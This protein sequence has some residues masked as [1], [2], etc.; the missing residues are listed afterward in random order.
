M[1]DAFFR[2][3]TDIEQTRRQIQTGLSGIASDLAR[4]RGGR[5]NMFDGLVAAATEAATKARLELAKV[6]NQINVGLRN[7][8][9]AGG[10]TQLNE[11]YKQ[12]QQVAAREARDRIRQQS[13]ALGLS[14]GETSNA[15]REGQRLVRAQVKELFDHIARSLAAESRGVQPGQISAR[16]VQRYLAGDLGAPRRYNQLLSRGPQNDDLTRQTLSGAATTQA[17]RREAAMWTEALAIDR[18]YVAQNSNELREQVAIAKSISRQMR[19]REAEEERAALLAAREAARRSPQE[20]A[21]RE[22]TARQ[23]QASVF[24]DPTYQQLSRGRAYAG[25]QV[26][27]P[28]PG[29]GEGL[30]RLNG[31]KATRAYEDYVQALTK[32]AKDLREESKRGSLS[33]SFLGGLT[34]SGFGGHSTGF[35]ATGI[36][37]SFGS[38]VKFTTQYQALQLIRNAF[39]DTIKEA[40]DYRDSLTD[41]E[42]A[43]GQGARVNDAYVD[44]LSNIS[45]FAGGNVGQALDAAARGV[46]AFTDRTAPQAEKQAAGTE[47][48][49]LATQL[50]VITGQTIPDAMGD[51]VAIGKSFELPLDQLGQIADAVSAAK[52][53]GGDPQ[54]I[55]QGT[56]N[57]AVALKAAGFTVADSAQLMSAVIAQLHES[58]QAAATR[59]SRIVS[60]SGTATGRQFFRS[61]N[62]DPNQSGKA[63]IVALAQVYDSLGEA[64]QKQALATLGGASNLR[65]FKAVIDTIKN[66]DGFI[67]GF[68]T[69]GRGQSEFDRKTQNL[70]GHLKI[71]AGTISNIQNEVFDSGAFAPFLAALATLQP[72]LATVETLLKLFNQLKDTIEHIPGL[73][74]E[75]GGV[76]LGE[77]AVGIGEIVL[78]TKGLNALRARQSVNTAE[79]ASLE[80]SLATAKRTVAQATGEETGLEAANIAAHREAIVIIED[81]ILALRGLTAARLQAGE[82][83]VAEAAGGRI[84][85]VAS[86]LPFGNTIGRGAEAARAGAGR[87]GGTQLLGT[88][89]GRLGLWG[90]ALVVSVQTIKSFQGALDLDTQSLKASRAALTNLGKVATPGDAVSAIQSAAKERGQSSSGF[91]GNVIDDIRKTD[92]RITGH[93]SDFGRDAERD[94]QVLN[95]AAR[96]LKAWQKAVDDY[97]KNRAQP[98]EFDDVFGDVS[99]IDSLKAGFDELAAAGAS[100]SRIIALLNKALDNTGQKGAFVPRGANARIGAALGLSAQDVIL[101]NYREGVRSKAAAAG[102]PLQIRDVLGEDKYNDNWSV[103]NQWVRDRIS[104]DKDL[105]NNWT[106]PKVRAEAERRIAEEMLGQQTGR[107]YDK[108]FPVKDRVQLGKDVAGVLQTYLDEALPEG[109]FL[110]PE[111]VN[112]AAGKMAD[113]L[114]GK[115]PSLDRD[116]LVA[117]WQSK[118]NDKLGVNATLTSEQQ[119]VLDPAMIQQAGLDVEQT[120]ALTGDP[121]AAQ[122][123]RVATISAQIKRDIRSGLTPS[124]A[125]I[126]AYAEAVKAVG[127]AIQERTNAMGMALQGTTNLG[128]AQASVQA[129]RAAVQ[130]TTYDT[131]EFW[132]SY[133]EYNKTIAQLADAQ[134]EARIAHRDAGVHLTGGAGDSLRQAQAQ[135]KDAQDRYNSYKNVQFASPADFA[136]GG[137]FYKKPP[138]TPKQAGTDTGK[139]F[140]AGVKTTDYYNAGKSVGE[141][142]IAGFRASIVP[143]KPGQPG[144]IGPVYTPPAPYKAPAISPDDPRWDDPRFAATHQLPPAPVAPK[145]AAVPKPSTAVPPI[146]QAELD[147]RAQAVNEA[148]AALVQARQQ[149][150][151]A[152]KQAREAELQRQSARIQSKVF[153]GAGIQE[154]TAQIQIARLALRTYAKNSTEWYNALGQL[155]QAQVALSNALL[156]AANN[157]RLLAIDLTNPVAQAHAVTQAALAKLRADKKLGAPKEVLN[158]DQ[159]A[160]REAQASEERAKFDQR[161]ADAQVNERLGRISHQAYIHYLQGEHDRLTAIAHK[162]RQQIDMLNEIDLLLLE[163]S[164]QLQGQF[165]LGDIKLPTPYEVRRSIAQGTQAGAGTQVATVQNVQIDISGGDIAVIKG[166]ISQYLGP[167]SFSRAA[168]SPPK[169]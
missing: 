147:R 144:F 42:V 153:P 80:A 57:A 63:S 92:A 14:Q 116:K 72:T 46:R 136:P 166:V 64:Q 18:R 127:D 87:L 23:L 129:A 3:G 53:Q 109:G 75:V 104:K 100:A 36:A 69:A 5:T 29:G 140:V 71:L 62:I 44:S 97:G 55:L 165:N 7:Q 112:D 120:T 1:A 167:G 10:G 103:Y 66:D 52:Q 56:A 114:V 24:N 60:A 16:G 160:I 93:G 32:R 107:Q 154:A 117:E 85:R 141:S 111:Q 156:E 21:V 30:Q 79:L 58:G 74:I 99:S 20:R 91:W 81:E 126:A 110:T 8:S 2:F 35:D 50:S 37:R 168:V 22:Q 131:T 95:Q 61:L 106:D 11:Q 51:L 149:A 54:Q 134:V 76:G 90:A 13:Q 33:Q 123:N 89:L 128:A 125:L 102:R 94:Q 45:R 59:I 73:N 98:G 38:T 49:R 158:Q 163:A 12:I 26:Y 6:G 151:E 96:D 119:R 115:D 84:G 4:A 70:S 27:G 65:E 113:F 130:R 164:Q 43:I 77:V 139:D 161:L 105:G 150:A 121:I 47:S 67:N 88:T 31:A 157:R 152:Q 15:V 138:I 155:R 48:A 68:D 118:L 148:R 17:M 25:G 133:A 28:L 142:I 82:A 145:P 124:D 9:L 39:T 19:K 78:A 132:N 162:T 137:K 146:D 169:I 83:G 34:S 86:Y 41:L 101:D 122:R 108:K 143:P 40:V 135:L 159:I